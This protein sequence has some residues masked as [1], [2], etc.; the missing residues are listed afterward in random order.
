MNY[1]IQKKVKVLDKEETQ[2][3]VEQSGRRE[4]WTSTFSDRKVYPNYESA[5]QDIYFEFRG[6]IVSDTNP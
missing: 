5:M 4:I 6:Q 1:R 2:Y 3:F